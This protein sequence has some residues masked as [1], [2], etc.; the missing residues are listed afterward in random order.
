MKYLTET[1]PESLGRQ[2]G[3]IVE[4]LISFV[5]LSGFMAAMTVWALVFVGKV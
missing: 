5:V 4:E 2:I 1:E 3:A